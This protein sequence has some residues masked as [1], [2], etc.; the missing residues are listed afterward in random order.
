[1]RRWVDAGASASRCFAC[2]GFRIRPILLVAA[3]MSI[4]NYD[5]H[6]CILEVGIGAGTIF[7]MILVH[8]IYN[9]GRL[10]EKQV[11]EGR[12]DTGGTGGD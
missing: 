12:H 3:E 4:C 1:M 11:H 10:L 2:P 6:A 8:F 7:V 5:H 9:E